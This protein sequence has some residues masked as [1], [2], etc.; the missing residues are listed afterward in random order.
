MEWNKVLLPS[1]M[2]VCMLPLSVPVSNDNP[3]DYDYPKALGLCQRPWRPVL[4]LDEQ[5]NVVNG[6]L[7]EL[8]ALSMEANMFRIKL[9]NN[10]SPYVLKVDNTN[11]RGQ[12]VCA[13]SIWHVSDNGTHI[14]T[15][16]EWR[17]HLICSNGQVEVIVSP[18][19]RPDGWSMAAKAP[20]NERLNDAKKNFGQVVNNTQ[21]MLWYVKELGAGNP[22]Y[23]NFLDGTRAAGS[24]TDL[25]YMARVGE[26]RCVMRDRGYAFAMNNLLVD[27]VAEEIN[28][29]S[30]SHVGQRFLG[31]GLSFHETPYYWYSSWTTNGQRDNTRFFVGTAQP[32]GHN[33]DFVALDWHVDTC[34]REVYVNNKYGFTERGSLDELIVLISLGHRVRLEYDGTILEANS[35][36]IS[37]QTVIAQSLEEMNRRGGSGADK[38]F[39]NTDTVWKWTT[40]HT[41]GKVKTYFYRVKDLTYYNRKT[42]STTIRWMVDTRPWKRVHS[43]PL[44]PT[45]SGDSLDTL[46]NAVRSGASIRFSLQ[47]DLTA[48]F[49]FTNAD[50]VRYDADRHTVFAQCLRHVSDKRD[51]VNTNE[52]EI[53]ARPFHWF[54]MISS[55]GVMA[56]SAWKLQ[57]RTQ[58][59]DTVAPEANITWFASY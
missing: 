24:I 55:D 59:Y 8:R 57:D 33:N 43:W 13:E 46:I 29:Q 20:F 40:A 49:F 17:H 48:G 56:M 39:F 7:D 27:E 21:A 1:L 10:G 15:S 53:Q 31:E 36:R 25:I 32:R 6:S 52:Y 42:T 37:E 34:W 51:Q 3:A 47:Q 44:Q 22:V 30:L 41:S 16:V 50:N 2:I 14:S 11:L 23:S 9:Y 12:H 54:L 45:F 4:K 28:A 35:L 26:T 19:S 38:Y 5:G 58:L 18:Y